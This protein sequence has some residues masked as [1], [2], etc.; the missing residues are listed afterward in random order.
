M[1]AAR[2]GD[3]WY[4]ECAHDKPQLVD[5]VIVSRLHTRISA[6]QNEGLPEFE[7]VPAYRRLGALELTASRS[8]KLLT[9]ARERLDQLQDLLSPR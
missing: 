3:D 8:L 4:Y 2:H 6:G 5:L 7:Q 1:E 9:A